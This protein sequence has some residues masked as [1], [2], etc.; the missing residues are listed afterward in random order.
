M[1]YPVIEI[2]D[3]AEEIEADLVVL[4]SR[5]H[6]AIE[7]LIV[8]SVAEGVVHHAR[9]PVLVVRGGQEAW[10]PQRVVVGDDGSGRGYGVTEA[11]AEMGRLL[12]ATTLLVHAH[13]GSLAQPEL[14][15]EERRLYEE[16]VEKSVSQ[17]AK[18][19]EERAVELKSVGGTLPETRIYRG[20]A[21]KALLETASENAP[22]SLIVVGSRGLG[23]AKRAFLGSVSTKVLRAAAGPVMV[24]P[25]LATGT[26]R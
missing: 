5:G 8:G 1:G 17:E 25:Y 21:A 24:L 2:L 16:A 11:A 18:R 9:G 13:P 20:D 4:G 6:G 15:E 12:E 26:A 22:P 19:L 23:A 14:P 10:P 3:L 7:R